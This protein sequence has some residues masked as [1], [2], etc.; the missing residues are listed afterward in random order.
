MDK[1]ISL[2]LNIYDVF[3]LT[4]DYSIIQGI[5]NDYPEFRIYTLCSENEKGYDNDKFQIQTVDVKRISLLNLFASVEVLWKSN[6]LMA[7]INANPSLFL[8]KRNHENS[9]WLN[10]D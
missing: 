8:Y 7:A 1:I 9:Y 5:R 3:I 2:N 4:D 10:V 6:C